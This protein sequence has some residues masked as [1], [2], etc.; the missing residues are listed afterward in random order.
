FSVA[1]DSVLGR[2][3]ARIEAEAARIDSIFQPLPLLRPAEETS[4]RRFG[5]AQQLERARELGVERLLPPARIEELRA[6][7]ELVTLEDS[8]HW[9]V[10]D[11]DYSSALV[12][13]SVRALLTEI[14]ERF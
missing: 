6:A 10:R 7:G 1:A 8:N 13:P 4:L 2:E 3:M 11:L 12:V 14:G 9:V 5:N